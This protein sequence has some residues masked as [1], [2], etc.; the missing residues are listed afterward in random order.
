MFV[1]NFAPIFDDRYIARECEMRA[2]DLLRQIILVMCCVLAVMPPVLGQ[3]TSEELLREEAED[4]MKKWL[5]QDVLYIITDD[6]RAIFS[7]LST[8]DEKEQFI[9]Q[10]WFRRDPDPRTS[11]NEFKEEHYRRIAYAND[12]FS[13][14]VD[15]WRTD[16]GRV[17]IIHGKPA[18]V[19]SHPAGGSYQRPIN[20]GGGQ[21]STYPFEIWRYRNIEGIGNDVV[22]EFV[23]PTMSGEYR[24]ALR[25]EEK[26]ALL[27]VPGAGL[28]AAEQMGLASKGD[29][30]FFSPGNRGSYPLMHESVRDNPFNRYET[31]AM[32]QAPAPIRYDD[33][34]ELVKVNV[35]YAALPMEVREDYFRLNDKQVLVPVTLQ[36]RNRDLSFKLENGVHVARVA[37]YGLV[38]SITNRVVTEFDDDLMVSY[39]PEGL[40]GGLLKTAM[41]QRVLSLDNKLRYKLDL[42]VKDLH[43]EKIGATRQSILPPAVREER[44]AASSLILSNTIR[45]LQNIPDMNERFVLGDVK[46][47]PSLSKEFTRKMQL[48]IYLHVYNAA[49]DQAS[50][51]PELSVTY[52][53][54][55]D[56]EVIRQAVDQKGESTQ[57]FSE[58]RIVLIK[59]L[60]FDSLEPGEYRLR[61]EVQDR[62]SNQ[63]VMVSEDFRLVEESQMALKD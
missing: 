35:E 30:P 4:Y 6:E 18:E 29:R 15:G 33:L 7:K 22:V 61:V 62:L 9:E 2:G 55:R 3:R 27:Y 52:S 49:L 8:V 32:I 59:A 19:E 60:S 31:Y 13:S 47:F 37:V 25:P 11:V 26:D 24:L 45:V 51:A 16:R 10:F 44:L 57:Y 40:Q 28:T 41:Y 21:T 34:K 53:L 39:S 20:E 5:D 14:G 56:G 63:Q 50:L 46:I 36:L 1:G 43:S 12:H 23:D 48:G 38:T 54:L 58:Q 17:Y 42:I